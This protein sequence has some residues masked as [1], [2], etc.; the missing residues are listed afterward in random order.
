MFMPIYAL[1]SCNL[2][3]EGYSDLITDLTPANLETIG[4]DPSTDDKPSDYVALESF[5]LTYPSYLDVTELGTIT[6]PYVLPSSANDKELENFKIRV[7]NPN[8]ADIVDNKY[9]LGLADGHTTVFVE[10]IPT[11]KARYFEISVGS[12]VPEGVYYIVNKKTNQYLLAPSITDG[13]I[14]L[15]RVG[16]WTNS[17]NAQWYVYPLDDESNYCISSE[18][19][20]YYGYLGIEYTANTNNAPVACY[21]NLLGVNSCV[22]IL[23]TNSGNFRLYFNTGQNNNEALAITNNSSNLSQLTYV[24]NLDFAD[25]W[26]LVEVTNPTEPK[27]GLAIGLSSV[28]QNVSTSKFLERSRDTLTGDYIVCGNNSFS[29]SSSMMWKI[30][31]DD[32]VNGAGRIVNMINLR[33]LTYNA[34]TVTLQMNYNSETQHFQV[35][36]VNVVPHQ[37]QYII[38]MNDKYLTM[39]ASGNVYMSSRLLDGS[40]WRISYDDANM[41]ARLFDFVYEGTDTTGAALS[42]IQTTTNMGY[43]PVV[44]ENSTADQFHS[45][46]LSGTVDI[47]VFRGHGGAAALQFG[48][49]EKG[50]SHHFYLVTQEGNNTSYVNAL[51]DNS[52]Y[53]VELILLLG[54]STGRTKPN[55]DNILE[56]LYDKGA[57]FVLG[58]YDSVYTHNGNEFL[59]KLLEYLASGMSIE[60]AIQAVYLNTESVYLPSY[61][62]EADYPIIYVG[63]AGQTIN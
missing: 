8:I 57:H 36:R 39:D 22:K 53:D 34:D 30:Y 14:Q 51:P 29:G 7:D 33:N 23:A 63:D 4:N 17:V 44:R 60:N 16:D 11:G 20:D 37:G 54:C 32:E 31:I 56:A 55:G 27:T 48:I 13:S 40:Y 62:I 3:C 15:S 45:D 28:I 42:F 9:I 38:M 46:L 26:M 5:G 21:T 49:G 25:E 35:K 43:T 1:E 47:L 18:V 2:Y 41:Q 58:T 50:N 10:H 6:I 19:E 59:T 12:V 52:L 61:G 24:D